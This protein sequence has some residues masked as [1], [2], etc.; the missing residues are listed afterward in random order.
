MKKNILILCGGVSPEHEISLISTKGILDALDRTKYTPVIVGISKTGVWHLETENNFYTGDFIADKI[1]LNMSTPTVSLKPYKNENKRGELLSQ[2]TK[3][4]FDC[5]FPML[6]GK[7][8]EDGTIQG[9]FEILGLPYVG[10]NVESSSVCMDKALT[11]TICQYQDIRVADYC[12]VY[13]A[14]EFKKYEKEV[15]KWGLP[16]FV[17]P[18][19]TGS[20]VGVYKVKSF[21]EIEEA[22]TK[23]LKYD[24]K[25]LIEKAIVGREIETAV[26]GNKEPKVALPGE[27]VV[28]SEAEF[29]SY[30]AK[31]ILPNAA[32]TL[33]PANLT[34]KQVEKAQNIA[35]KIFQVL[36]MEMFV[37]IELN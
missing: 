21:D 13:S 35:K 4:E 29:Y 30:E 19:R 15:K 34:P 25:V 11:K 10:C 3:I 5:I 24:E 22:I 36:V 26:L 27:I 17:K 18:A 28:S 33:A 16:V 23:A 9:L 1:K 8:G 20:S 12:Y 31:Y 6:H 7:N 37:N 2:N 14:E 32:K